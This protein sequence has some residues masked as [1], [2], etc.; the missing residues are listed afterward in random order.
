MGPLLLSLHPPS[1]SHQRLTQEGA[2]MPYWGARERLLS[3]LSVGET[4]IA[5]VLHC[6]VSAEYCSPAFPSLN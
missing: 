4:T 1:G 2:V 6:S 3:P 5:S